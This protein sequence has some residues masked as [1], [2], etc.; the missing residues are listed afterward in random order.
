M[1]THPLFDKLFSGAPAPTGPP[2]SGEELK[3]SGMRSVFRHTPDWYREAFRSA[4]E[5]FPCGKTFTV[6]DVRAI[7]GDPPA[8]EVSSNCMGSLMVMIASKKLAK[9][10]GYYVKAKRPCMNSTELACWVRI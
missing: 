8:A 7:A 6:E 4:V 3:K 9:K 5:Q 10:T 1:S 2:L